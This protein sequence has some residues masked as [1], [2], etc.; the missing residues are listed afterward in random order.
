MDSSR[1]RPPPIPGRSRG[2]HDVLA[3][4]ATALV[5]VAACALGIVAVG[6]V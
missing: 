3:A 4:L 2:A 6:L 1:R 5:A